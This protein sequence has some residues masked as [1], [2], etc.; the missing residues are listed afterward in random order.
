MLVT[1]LVTSL[2]TNEVIA[3]G[4]GVREVRMMKLEILTSRF[5][6]LKRDLTLLVYLLISESL[7]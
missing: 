7:S 1:S 6:I 2:V 3:V 4:N 5:L